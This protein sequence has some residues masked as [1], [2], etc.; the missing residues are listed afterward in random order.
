[1]FKI[2]QYPFKHIVEDNFL[3]NEDFVKIKNRLRKLIDNS[4]FENNKSG[5]I[6]NQARISFPDKKVIRESSILSNKELLD[7][8]S[9]YVPKMLNHLKIISPNKINL[10][11]T[12]SFQV[13]RTDKNITYPIHDDSSEK[14]LSIVIYL[15]P[16]NNIG[17]YLYLPKSNKPDKLVDWRPN[18][19]L[20]FSRIEGKT[21]HSYQG[22]KLENRYTIILNI[23]TS[24]KNYARWIE[25]G[26][27]GKL[28]A[29]KI[30][31]K[32]VCFKLKEIYSY[33]IYSKNL[34]NST[35]KHFLL[36]K[37]NKRTSSINRKHIIN[38][39]NDLRIN[40]K[41]DELNFIGSGKSALKAINKLGNN[42]VIIG[43]NFS[44]LLP[45]YHDIYFTEWC[46][47]QHY[48][49]LPKVREIYS[50]RSKFMN[51]LIMKNL[52]SKFNSL[53]LDQKYS[54]TS[55]YLYEASIP[56]ISE[57]Q[58]RFFIKQ[59]LNN[60]NKFICQSSSSTITAI[61]LAYLGGFKKI[62]LYGVDFGG[63]YFWDSEE[64]KTNTSDIM[65][66]P[67]SPIRGYKYGSVN[68]YPKPKSSIPSNHA[69]ELAIIPVS[70]IIDTLKVYFKDHGFV[71]NNIS[72]KNK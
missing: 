42:D 62:N 10:F 3:K 40:K 32:E 54:L 22:N 70:K 29:T 2:E 9:R 19:Y 43:G 38:T 25:P 8:Y 18:R 14:L 72:Q 16:Q 27:K 65:M 71:I 53:P 20:A 58:L 60:K 36:R 48:K 13:S 1:M 28:V 11:D 23:L 47:K 6:Y 51:H 67:D 49:I 17:T 30:Y 64:F 57:K 69:T 26:Y 21:R 52:S 59:S 33:M 5:V 56:I 35:S 44:C 46:G 37:L 7:F 34:I 66:M 50:K 39:L 55:K 68:L 12:F 61:F 41:T 45:I 4:K 63:G 31:L 15:S 24:K